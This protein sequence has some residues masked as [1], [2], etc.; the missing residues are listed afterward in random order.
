MQ[1]IRQVIAMDSVHSEIRRSSFK[2]HS[3]S[4]FI[5]IVIWLSA[6]SL[7]DNRLTTKD[8]INNG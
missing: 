8:V 2:L 4:H 6:S 7:F 3:F 5:L 1:Y